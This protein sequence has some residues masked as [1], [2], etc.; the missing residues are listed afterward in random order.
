MDLLAGIVTYATKSS[1]AAYNVLVVNYYPPATAPFTVHTTAFITAKV[2]QN[3][4][5]LPIC[6]AKFESLFGPNWWVK[7]VSESSVITTTR[8]ILSAT[9]FS[10]CSYM[11]ANQQTLGISLHP[12]EGNMTGGSGLHAGCCLLCYGNVVLKFPAWNGRIDNYGQ[13]GHL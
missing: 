12:L 3:R 2:L 8:T 5:W 1:T 7:S 6:F 9:R 11:H 4:W 10:Y 13:Y